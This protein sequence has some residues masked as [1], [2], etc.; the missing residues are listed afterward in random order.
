MTASLGSRRWWTFLR[1]DEATCPMLIDLQMPYQPFML[2][3]MIPMSNSHRLSQN[4]RT[5][6]NV[7]QRDWSERA[8]ML[9]N[10]ARGFDI[11]DGFSEGRALQNP[12]ENA[13]TINRIWGTRV[14]LE[15][16]KFA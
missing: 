16:S 8:F 10:R 4:D 12:V 11:L 3:N 1:A 6:L 13:I 5:S 7:R 2:A 14:A 15:W 9:H